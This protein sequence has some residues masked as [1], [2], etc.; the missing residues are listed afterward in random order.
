MS[1]NGTFESERYIRVRTE[2]PDVPAVRTTPLSKNISS[3]VNFK[4]VKGSLPDLPPEVIKKMS[5]DQ[6]YLYRIVKAV[7][8]GSGYFNKDVGLRTASLGKMHHTRW[9]TL[10]NRVLRLYCSTQKPFRELNRLVRFLVE[11]YAPA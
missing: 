3:I 10:A 6:A 1:Q 4:T 9:I 5:T 2:V 8:T 11:V 7:A